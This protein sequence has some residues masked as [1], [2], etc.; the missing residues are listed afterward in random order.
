VTDAL[1]KKVVEEIP[2]EGEILRREEERKLRAKMLLHILNAVAPMVG[3]SSLWSSMSA[4]REGA[5]EG[6]QDGSGEAASSGTPDT[7]AEPR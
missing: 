1:E 5:A 4:P 2:T 3:V 6:G 7:D